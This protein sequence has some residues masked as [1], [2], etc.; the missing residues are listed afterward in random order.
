MTDNVVEKVTGIAERV[1][2]QEGIEIVEVTFAGRGAHRLLRITID[3]PEGV[4]HADCELVSQQ[5]GTILDVEDVVPGAGYRLE[6]T[7]PG[8]ERKLR[9]LGD[10][11]RFQGRKAHVVLREPIEGR[12]DWEGT[13]AGVAGEA[14]TLDADGRPVRFSFDQVARANLKLDW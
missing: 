7:S 5:V 3:K 6:V 10:F 9:R 2:R 14:I 12:K 4:S 8:V 1:A 11:E 13:L